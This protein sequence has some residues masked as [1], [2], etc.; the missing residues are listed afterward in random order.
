MPGSPYCLTLF[1]LQI[2]A[3]AEVIDIKFYQK[4]ADGSEKAFLT[5]AVAVTG[6]L[7]C[8]YETKNTIQCCLYLHTSHRLPKLVPCMFGE[9]TDLRYFEEQEEE[10]ERQ[11][12]ELCTKRGEEEVPKELIF[13]DPGWYA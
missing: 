8:W 12:D 4:Q 3:G 13:R 7:N 5:V 10:K 11:F 6:L 1:H 9:A 2:C